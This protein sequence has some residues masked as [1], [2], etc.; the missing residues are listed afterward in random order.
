MIDIST[1][2]WRL[3]RAQDAGKV[4]GGDFFGVTADEIANAYE[5]ATCKDYHDDLL[6]MAEEILKTPDVP[7]ADITRRWLHYQVAR[8]EWHARGG[9]KVGIYT[10]WC[11]Q[12][13]G[14]VHEDPLRLYNQR[15]KEHRDQLLTLPQESLEQQECAQP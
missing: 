15:I 6:L 13:Y 3:A 12:F 11:R 8:R 14:G 4:E 1:R 9:S 7:P 10:G 2:H 5:G